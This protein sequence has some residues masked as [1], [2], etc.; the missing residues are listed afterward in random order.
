MNITIFLACPFFFF[1]CFGPALIEF[2]FQISCSFLLCVFRCV[3]YNLG[4]KAFLACPSLSRQF[5]TSA[6]WLFWLLEARWLVLCCVF[7]MY[8]PL[9]LNSS[10]L[11]RDKHYIL[12]PIY[13]GSLQGC[14]YIG[15]AYKIYW[16]SCVK[17]IHTGQMVLRLVEAIGQIFWNSLQ[18][19]FSFILLEV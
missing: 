1:F 5:L 14:V 16:S 7:S 8:F 6:S 13:L 9:Y 15:E 18:Q 3:L 11:L 17:G 2:P 19:K 10:K 4:C 12:L